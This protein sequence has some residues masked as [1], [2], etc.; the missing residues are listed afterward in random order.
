MKPFVV[1][2]EVVSHYI[3]MLLRICIPNPPTHNNNHTHQVKGK[4]ADEAILELH[5]KV[6]D[7]DEVKALDVPGVVAL[8]NATKLELERTMDDIKRWPAGDFTHKR[9]QAETLMKT[10]SGHFDTMLDYMG[11]LQE[12][13]NEAS[14]LSPGSSGNCA[15]SRT[16]H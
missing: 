10:F 2:V 4:P 14:R 1:L 13:V 8:A 16:R 9:S 6:A 12:A 15:T 5:E 11:C 3:Y 7:D